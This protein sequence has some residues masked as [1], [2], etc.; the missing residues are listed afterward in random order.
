MFDASSVKMLQL[1]L[2]KGA[3][4]Q[5]SSPFGYGGN[6]LTA[7][8][9]SRKSPTIVEFLFAKGVSGIA[10][11]ASGKTPLALAR[12][13]RESMV[14][15]NAGEMTKGNSKYLQMYEE[16]LRN[17]DAVIALLLKSGAEK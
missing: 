1:L 3:N 5:L 12:E 13:M 6:W 15:A 17:T 16:Q 8:V 9:R 10:K 14:R 11:D 7:S 4:L 2:A